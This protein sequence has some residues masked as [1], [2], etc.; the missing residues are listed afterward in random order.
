MHHKSIK[1]VVLTFLLVVA[2][3]L[4]FAASIIYLGCQDLPSDDQ[5]SFVQE[6]GD[7]PNITWDPDMGHGELPNCSGKL[8]AEACN[9]QLKDY[10]GNDWEL[11]DHY[12]EIVVLDFSAIWSAR[13]QKSAAS[14]QALQDHY[15]DQGLVLVTI[16]V[17][18]LYGLE[19]NEADLNMWANTFGL[20]TVSVL[21]GNDSLHDASEERWFNLQTLPTIIVI[22]HDRMVIY[23]TGGWNEL[24][25]INVLDD[26]TSI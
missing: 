16:L 22:N 26:L 20:T 14:I 4:I 1:T 3:I 6:D 13:C 11:Y 24:R 7:V 18:N 25:L 9:L 17:Q 5:P 12:G 19:P 2:N 21:G 8:G 15:E 23:K 10:R